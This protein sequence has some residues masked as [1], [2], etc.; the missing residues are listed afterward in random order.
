MSCYSLLTNILALCF[1]DLTFG[2]NVHDRICDRLLL[3]NRV[4]VQ[5]YLNQVRALKF[6]NHF[7]SIIIKIGFIS[8][9]LFIHLN[10]IFSIYHKNRLYFNLSVLQIIISRLEE[11]FIL[12]PTA[13]PNLN[14]NS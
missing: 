5:D 9:Y 11:I 8:I 13:L 4:R 6:I 1:I 14:E 3:R 7:F 10:H 2:G 12:E